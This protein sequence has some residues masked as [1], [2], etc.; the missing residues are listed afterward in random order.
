MNW[1]FIQIYPNYNITIS[2]SP[3]D[4]KADSFLYEYSID[5]EPNLDYLQV[6]DKIYCYLNKKN[7]FKGE[8]GIF[9]FMEQGPN[10]YLVSSKVMDVFKQF[11]I[12]YKV[13]DVEIVNKEK[14]NITE[15]Y[16]WIVLLDVFDHS[17]DPELSGIKF[18][19]RE[20]EKCIISIDKFV[21][22]S[23]IDRDLFVPMDSHSLRKVVC[24]ERFK[25]A[26]L[27]SGIKNLDFNPVDDMIA[28]PDHIVVY[29]GS[30]K[31]IKRP[32]S[33]QDYLDRHRRKKG[34]K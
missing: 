15:T 14:Y 7:S 12:T 8:D 23:N 4:K 2:S 13:T 17:L 19:V 30:L 33:A 24:S 5:G 10:M 11:N 16:Y 21:F 20:G 9:D 22:V 27:D 32:P 18:G 3:T 6:P 28:V 34:L 26:L 1:F 25:N 29:P 31:V